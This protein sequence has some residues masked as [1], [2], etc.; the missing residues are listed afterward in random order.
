MQGTLP[1]ARGLLYYSHVIYFTIRMGSALPFA[2]FLLYQLAD[3]P[4]PHHLRQD[5]NGQ[6]PRI[7]CTPGEFGH[8]FDGIWMVVCPH[9]SK[10]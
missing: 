5:V 6:G 1:F 10:N 8:R 9:G 4:S 7:A 3:R 2:E